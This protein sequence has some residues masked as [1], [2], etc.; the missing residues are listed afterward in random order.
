[1]SLNKEGPIN[2]H[3]AQIVQS[4]TDMQI[5]F[6][7]IGMIAILTVYHLHTKHR[8]ATEKAQVATSASNSY[9]TFHPLDAHAR[10]NDYDFIHSAAFCSVQ[11]GIEATKDEMAKAQCLIDREKTKIRP[12]KAHLHFMNALHS[13]S[14]SNPRS[15]G[16][17]IDQAES[18]SESISTAYSFDPRSYMPKKT[19]RRRQEVM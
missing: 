14:L 1:M 10:A 8:Q 18:V 7:F 12:Q 2:D 17:M 11:T 13:H 4:S 16:H 3:A 15:Y 9:A 5:D 6:I 19:T